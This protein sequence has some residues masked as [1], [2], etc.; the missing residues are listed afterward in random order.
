MKKTL[1][2]K[3]EFV[4]DYK[5]DILTFKM[6]NR[7][8]KKSI[9]FQNFVIDIDEKNYITGIRILDA[10]KVFKID[11]YILKNIIK[12]QFKAEVKNK[13]ITITLNFVSKKRNKLVNLFDTKQNYVQQIIAPATQN[14]SDSRVECAT[15]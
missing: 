10:S 3:G 15:T 6:Q 9:E 14:I 1:K 12:G 8:Y 13:I 2:G 5:H 7:N 4:Y 11:K